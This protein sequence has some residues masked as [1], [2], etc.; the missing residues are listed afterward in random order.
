MKLDYKHLLNFIKVKPTMDDLSQKLFQLGHEHEVDG[1]VFNMEFTPNRGDCLS[2]IGLARD[3]NVFYEADLS[4]DLFTDEIPLL[5]LEF[6]NKSSDKCPEISFLNI[7]IDGKVSKYKDYLESYFVDLKINKNN[8]FTDISNYIAYEM[9]QPT[10]SYDFSSIS[11]PITIGENLDDCDFLTLLNKTIKL[12]GNDLVFKNQSNVINLAGIIGGAQTA[13]SETTKNVLIECAYFEPE[14]IIGRAIKYDLH[15]DASHKF[16]RGVDPLCHQKVLRR[17]IQIV[18]DHANIVNLGIYTESTS[19]YKETELDINL[20]K[21]NSILGLDIAI[22]EYLS[23]LI[24]LGFK[25]DE[26]IKVPSYRSDIAHQNDLAEELARVIGYDNIPAETIS[27]P[28]VVFSKDPHLDEEQI[29][30]FLIDNGFSEVINSPFC[31]VESKNVI[32][33]DNPLDSNREFLRTNLSDSLVENLIY[34]EKRQKDSIKLFEIADIYTLI[35][36]EPKKTRNLCVIASGRMGNN[37]RDFSKIIN[38]KYLKEVLLDV[39][40]SP[41]NIINIDRKNLDSKSKNPIFLFEIN[42]EEFLLKVKYYIG[43]NQRSSGFI[44]Y[45]PISELPLSKRDISFSVKDHLSVNKLNSFIMNFKNPLLKEV[46]M[47]DYFNNE[48]SNQIKMGF[49]FIFQSTEK[50]LTDEEVD[51]VISS[52]MGSTLKIDNIEIPGHNAK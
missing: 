36:G 15:S 31:A 25:I 52:I 7:E 11:G 8:F 4:L 5:N 1:S 46:F 29:K 42:I 47:F 9:G 28:K 34:N 41:L 32:Q 20:K 17:F 38:E 45:R 44:Q 22:D 37:Y 48:K 21:I 50:T 49:R 10:H 13:C 19:S 51:D 30:L 43:K 27:L 35:N 3:L 33:V 6:I 14:S 39:T 12:K 2:L 26:G 16:E 23:A 40:E 18:S 24:K